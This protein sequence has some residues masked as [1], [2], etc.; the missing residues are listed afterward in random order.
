MA[1][2]RFRRQLRGHNLKIVGSN[3]T[4]ATKNKPVNSNSWRAS[5]FGDY[6][7][8]GSTVEAEERERDDPDCSTAAGFWRCDHAATL[9][10]AR[11]PSPSP[12]CSA[13]SPTSEW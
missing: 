1:R 11:L 10:L 8:P 13:W 6:F 7:A 9:C 2:L 3:P 5:P 4:R 12:G